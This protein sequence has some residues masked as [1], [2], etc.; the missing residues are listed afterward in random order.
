MY[1][2]IRVPKPRAIH[3]SDMASKLMAPSVGAQS[4]P[5]DY[6]GQLLQGKQDDMSALRA[7]FSQDPSKLVTNLN[8]RPNVSLPAARYSMGKGIPQ[9][10]GNVRLSGNVDQWISQAYRLMGIR[11]TP[12]ALAHE[13][14]LINHESG[15]NPRAVNRWDSNAKKGT[16]SMGIEQTIMSTFL[17]NALKGHGNIWNPVDNIAASLGYRKRRYGSYDIGNYKGGY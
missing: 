11:L 7:R 14:Y 17:G 15:G 13:K 1:S 5:T 10:G 6:I 8:W 12:T 16:P 4:D 2:H 3:M 9:G